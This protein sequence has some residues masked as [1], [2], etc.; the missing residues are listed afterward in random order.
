MTSWDA[1]ADAEAIAPLMAG[2][3]EE[4]GRLR[5]IFSSAYGSSDI[6]MSTRSC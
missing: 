3:E 5:R 2:S 1:D 6:L 4:E